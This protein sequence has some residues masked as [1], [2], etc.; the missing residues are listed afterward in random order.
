MSALARPLRSLDD[1]RR[2][3]LAGLVFAVLAGEV[4]AALLLWVTGIVL[5]LLALAPIG[6][7]QQWLWLPW[8]I[9]GAW[10]LVG[11]IGWGYLVSAVVAL[12]VADSIERRGL[13][14]PAAGWL[15]A[16]VAISG[17]GAMAVVRGGAH[18]GAARVFVAVVAG[19][20]LV[21]LLAFR[22]DGSVRPWRWSVSRRLR[23]LTVL[24]AALAGV[25]YSATHAF[26]ADG[27]GGTYTTSTV[28]AR[29]G[30]VETV[31]VGL[32][33]TNLP[34][35][36][37]SATLTGPGIAHVRVSGLVL[38]R[39]GDRDPIPP[40][41]RREPGALRFSGYALHPTQLPYRVAAGHGVWLGALVTL[42]SCGQAKLDTLSLHYT[43]LG[44]P[45]EETIALSTPLTL[46]CR[47]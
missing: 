46:R 33:R 35:N 18:P 23:L 30:H 24:L 37:T 34:A 39:D 17:Y 10:A 1:W 31:D 32:S 43:V 6:G 13:Q 44:V 41:V 8:R 26:A 22:T 21:R 42:S 40:A 4:L 47:R 27:S 15:R 9:D 20:I 2:P 19:A 7:G 16:A 28:I 3:S 25:S 38:S 14:R 45:T 12:L 11:A 5:A 29:P 36:I